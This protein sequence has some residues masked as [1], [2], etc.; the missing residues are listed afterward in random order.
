MRIVIS[1]TVGIGKSTTTKA[2]IKALTKKGFKVNG[3]E[4][5]AAKSI[6]LDYYYKDPQG[7]AFIAQL[8]FLMERFK[9]WLIDEKYREDN[10]LGKKLITIY[11]RHFLDDYV[12]A[13]LHSIK[14]N[15]SQFSSITYQCVY[16]ELLSKMEEMD[17]K[18]D[19]FIMLKAPLNIIIER[20]KNRGR[21]EE[22][23]V[24]MKYWED[25]FYNYYERP[26]FKNHFKTNVKNLVYV[27]TS[28]KTTD[29]IVEEILKIIKK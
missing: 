23:D 12:F 3:I 15:I 14:N 22:K 19:Y 13:E 16:K 29:I 6:Y 11:D 2:L 27:E 21:K 8:D 28:N 26:M 20:L 10:K 25:L 1:G 9:T 4:E 18:P 5:K 24:E 7:W 17:A